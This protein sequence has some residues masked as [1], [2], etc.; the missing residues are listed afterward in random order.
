MLFKLNL[1]C[2]NQLIRHQHLNKP[3]LASQASQKAS[4]NEMTLESQLEAEFY[5]DDADADT[6]DGDDVSSRSHHPHEEFEPYYGDDYHDQRLP[7]VEK[8][9]KKYFKPPFYADI[10]GYHPP[11]GVILNPKDSSFFPGLEPGGL[12]GITPKF[13]KFLRGHVKNVGKKKSLP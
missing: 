6:D 4:Q 1:D 13:I 3:C 11:V 5:Y 8:S 10:A 2:N 7:R 12:A 9:K